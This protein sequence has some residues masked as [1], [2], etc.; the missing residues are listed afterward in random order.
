VVDG[1]KLNHL[2]YIKTNEYMGGFVKNIYATN[3]KSGKID[4]GILGIETD[5]L[6]QW[7][8]LLPALEKRLT[9]ISDIYL[10]NVQ[11]S[12]VKFISK[13]SGQKD[14]PIKNI[15]LKKISTGT[16]HEKKYINE[17]VINFRNED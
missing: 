16:I 9:P 3:I 4:Q 6:Y 12:D 15:T 7:K 5:V 17:N 10:T 1:A 8:D 2:V 14:L 11:A 13:I